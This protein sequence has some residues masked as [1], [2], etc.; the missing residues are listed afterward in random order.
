MEF[1]RHRPAGC[2]AGSGAP[3]VGSR[4]ERRPRAVPVAARKLMVF[5]TGLIHRVNVC[6]YW[7]P[8]P[9]SSDATDGL[10]QSPPVVAVWSQEGVVTTG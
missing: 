6:R 3:C 7:P 4:R 8:R 1:L 9:P 10:V 2:I 5:I